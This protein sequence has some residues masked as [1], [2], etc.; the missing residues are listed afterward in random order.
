MIARLFCRWFGHAWR[1]PHKAEAVPLD[2][3]VCRRCT[4]TRPVKVRKVK[5][6]A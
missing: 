6:A 4:A 3:R 2:S 1:R 5:V